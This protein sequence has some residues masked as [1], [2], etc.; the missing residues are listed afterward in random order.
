MARLRRIRS[1]CVYFDNRVSLGDPVRRAQAA[2]R[3]K[4][5][6]RER[7]AAVSPIKYGAA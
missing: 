1:L 2:F 5:T 6:V 3:K 7:E 4:E